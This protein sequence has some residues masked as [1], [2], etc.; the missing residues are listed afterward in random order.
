MPLTKLNLAKRLMMQLKQ[1]SLNHTQV[2]PSKKHVCRNVGF[3][4]K[5]FLPVFFRYP[6]RM[7]QLKAMAQ[8]YCQ[9]N[10]SDA[11]RDYISSILSSKL[12]EQ[13]PVSPQQ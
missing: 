4:T 9:S 13:N 11:T 6:L 2:S 10:A 7:R 5:I 12:P 3:L 1:G 8:A